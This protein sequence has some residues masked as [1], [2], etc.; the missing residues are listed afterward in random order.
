MLITQVV[1]FFK[2]ISKCFYGC[3]CLCVSSS[4]CVCGWTLTELVSLS[5]A[6]EGGI[7]SGAL[8]FVGTKLLQQL[9][10]LLLTHLQQTLQ[11]H[12]TWAHLLK[13]RHANAMTHNDIH[14]QHTKMHWIKCLKLRCT[15]IKKLRGTFELFQGLF[16][17]QEWKEVMDVTHWL[18]SVTFT[19]WMCI[20][21]ANDL[22][23][24][25]HNTCQSSRTVWKMK[26][27]L[28]WQMEQFFFF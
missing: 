5:E 27:F 9:T 25:R 7:E 4:P 12:L 20:H 16:L 24:R 13:N 3:V 1:F 2:N 19:V 28:S 8:L 21:F 10:H 6:G 17:S 22:Y 23:K 18:V 26:L 15:N 11:G 14:T